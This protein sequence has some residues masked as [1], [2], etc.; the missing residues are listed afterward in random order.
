MKSKIL[1]I[2]EAIEVAKELKRK[3]KSIVLVGGF[4]DI[5][6]V[7]HIKFLEKAKKLSDILFIMLEDDEKLR[8]VKG[9]N[10]PIHSQKER[11]II[12]SSV[13]SADYIILLKRMTND[14]EYDKLV[15]Q[16]APS[17]IAT[18]YPD[19]FLNHKIRQAK[20][21]NGKVKYAIKRIPKYSTTKFVKLI[22]E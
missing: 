10:R 14:Q 4:F 5:L 12:L 16:I 8:K 19:A 6:H 2:K 22:K 18:T 3:N 1:N 13:K 15:I 21:V 11:A 20:L 7:G 17:I 9:E